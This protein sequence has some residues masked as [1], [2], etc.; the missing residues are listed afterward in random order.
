[1]RPTLILTALFT[2]AAGQLQAEEVNGAR[3]R[4]GADA[5]PTVER[6]I[7]KMRTSLSVQAVPNSGESVAAAEV[8]AAK[9]RMSALASRTKMAM[10]ETHAIGPNMHVMQVSPLAKGEAVTE[11]LA[12]LAAD[13]EVEYAV[14]DRRVYVHAPVV[15]TDTLATGQWY[16]QAVQPSAINAY[17]AWD[18]T[19]GDDSVV[20]AVADT[21]VRFDHPDLKAVATGGRLLPGYDFVSGESATSFTAANDGDG[22]DA[23]P[24]DPGDA[25]NTEPVPKSSWHGTRV[26][27]IIGALSNNGKGVAGITW[28]GRILPV[29]VLGKCGGFNSD[30]LAGL[31]WAAGVS[32]AGAPPLPSTPAKVINVSLG[33]VGNC[34]SASANV[35]SSLASMGVL[36]V[37]SAGNEGGPVDSPANCPGAMAI[38]GI[39]HVGTKVGY[40]SLGPQIKLAAP[41][42]NC[43]DDPGC[44]YSIDTTTNAGTDGA[45]PNNE[46][47]TGR[48][49]TTR[50]IGTSF[51]SPIVSGIA[52]LMLA[53]NGNL[54]ATQLI[55]R[56]QEG[57]KPFPTT[58]DTTPAPPVCH[59][60]TGPNDTQGTECICT[61]AVCGAGMANANGSVQAALRPLATIAN[62]GSVSPGA[63]ITLDG[64][65]SSAANNHTIST[66]SWVRGGGVALSTTA[67]ANVTA[68]TSGTSTVCLTVVDDVG[69]QDTAKIVL[70]TTSATIS[71]TDAGTNPCSSEVSVTATDAS[72][73][74]AGTDT[75]T[76]TL[77][78]SGSPTA[79]LAV[80]VGLSGSAAN[81]T[82]YQSIATTVNFAAGAATALV[83]LTP[84]D[85]AVVDGSRTATLTVQSG[86][87]YA[88][89]TP[90]S[91]SITIADNDA[92][93]P[94]PQSSGGGG[95]GGALD[96]LVLMGLTLAVLAMLGRARLLPPRHA[97]QLRHHGSVEQRRARR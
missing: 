26:S 15:P 6:F 52:G 64:S 62:P 12:R 13:S 56:L 83:T 16:L 40:S 27:G 39:R 31:N 25:C 57:A 54:K 71:A 85:N 78:R 88:V 87:G 76:F 44:L 70:T 29:R 97:K 43:P 79:A 21:G 96:P 91:A 42:G 41:A 28:S 75:G 38:A 89:G 18:T 23:D 53:V 34:D 58:S 69:K 59:L 47:Y 4:P 82:A 5:E 22:R 3:T 9:Q 63:N 81:G 19:T 46:G 66:Y 2:L 72:A 30:V 14:P 51:S 90:A 11:T 61:T 73:A 93:A 95:G 10:S 94:A 36:V 84:I 7:V 74:E 35:I 55:A 77:T 50:N 48:S 86:S 37:V 65:N 33:S 49:T 67:T 45:V 68:P 20:I 32:F 60:P 24:L 92:P 1:M 17:T 8:A 80:T